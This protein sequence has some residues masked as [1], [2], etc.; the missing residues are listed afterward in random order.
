MGKLKAFIFIVFIL[1]L[2]EVPIYGFYSAIFYLKDRMFSKNSYNEIYDEIIKSANENTQREIY[3]YLKM[4]RTFAGL[5]SEQFDEDELELRRKRFEKE[6]SL[7]TRIAEDFIHANFE[8]VEVDYHSGPFD[9]QTPYN[10]EKVKNRK[11][12][13][14]MKKFR[15]Q[16]RTRLN[17]KWVYYG[18]ENPYC[19]IEN[20]FSCDE[21]FTEKYSMLEFR[22]GRNPA[23]ANSR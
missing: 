7:N 21:Q 23:S 13:K 17:G 9:L 6:N 10:L 5:R 15:V 16:L 22:H 18:S 11:F 14:E 20:S 3:E 1:I 2:L 12:Q 8:I 4:R 19:I